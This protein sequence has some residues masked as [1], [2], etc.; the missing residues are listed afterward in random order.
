MPIPVNAPTN[1]LMDG[2]VGS[3]VLSGVNY[4]SNGNLLTFTNVSTSVGVTMAYDEADRVASVAMSTGGT[5]RY[6]Y[7]PDSKR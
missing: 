7:N 5:E 6:G 4:D 3:P 1:Q 2:P